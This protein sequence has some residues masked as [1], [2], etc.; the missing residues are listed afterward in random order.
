MSQTSHFWS[1]LTNLIVKLSDI[2]LCEG[3]KNQVMIPQSN[4]ISKN[5]SKQ[6]KLVSYING[7][8]KNIKQTCS[9]GISVF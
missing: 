4:V 9:F 1:H 8:L 6:L 7:N 2:R 5:L 3:N